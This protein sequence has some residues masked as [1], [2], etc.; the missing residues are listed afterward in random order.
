MVLNINIANTQNGLTSKSTLTYSS[1]RGWTSK[2]ALP[3]SLGDSKT[4]NLFEQNQFERQCVLNFFF[5]YIPY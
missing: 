1:S 4:G 5:V 2:V 3:N